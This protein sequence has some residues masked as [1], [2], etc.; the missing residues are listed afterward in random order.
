MMGRSQPTITTVFIFSQYPQKMQQP[1]E[2]SLFLYTTF[3]F[4]LSL[5]CY[6]SKKKKKKKSIK[7]GVSLSENPNRNASEPF[8]NLAGVFKRVTPSLHTQSLEFDLCRKKKTSYQLCSF[9]RWSQ[10]R[11]NSQR[12]EFEWQK[13]IKI[14]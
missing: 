11:K 2:V 7:G 6:L 9:V 1:E 13:R 5:Q 3:P 8:G 14:K 12:S 10:K 4:D